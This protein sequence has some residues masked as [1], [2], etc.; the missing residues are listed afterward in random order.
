MFRP[1]FLKYNEFS[2]V[3]LLI[4]MIAI[5]WVHP[6]LILKFINLIFNESFEY[7]LGNWAM[8]IISNFIITIG[9]GKFI[10]TGSK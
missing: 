8:I 3:I 7:N 6:Y 2:R 10:T 9:I 1:Y 5:L 4:A